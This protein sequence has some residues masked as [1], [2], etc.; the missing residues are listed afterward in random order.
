MAQAKWYDNM[1]D[2]CTG[3]ALACRDAVSLVRQAG[4]QRIF[5]ETD[6]LQVIQLWENRETQRSII[7]PVLSELDDIRLAFSEFTFK[8]AS[9]YCNKVAHEL[10]KQVTDTNQSEVWH[11]TPACI[12]DLVLYETPE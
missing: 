8:F 9:R 2:A 7:A 10:A 11:V 5:L 4:F 3:E 1:L 12:R 6:C